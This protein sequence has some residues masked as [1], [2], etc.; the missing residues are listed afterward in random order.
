MCR[1]IKKLLDEC[2]G[3]QRH[4]IDLFLGSQS[5]LGPM[6]LELKESIQLLNGVDELRKNFVLNP[7]EQGDNMGAFAKR[8]VRTTI[9]LN[10][11]V[12]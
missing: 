4:F 10:S 2:A 9:F 5:F 3:L 12:F 8:P 6:L 11:A 7:S 1:R